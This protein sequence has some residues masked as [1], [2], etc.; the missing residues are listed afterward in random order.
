MINKVDL[1]FIK[2]VK[3]IILFLQITT[4]KYY[5]LKKKLL[6]NILNNKLFWAPFFFFYFCFTAH[7]KHKQQNLYHLQIDSNIP[8]C[9]FF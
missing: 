6:L 2:L 7:Y 8:F 1:N 4:S 3:K 5:N 9:F